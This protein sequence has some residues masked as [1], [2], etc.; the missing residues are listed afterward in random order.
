MIVHQ[1]E[2]TSVALIAAALVALGSGICLG[3]EGP[4][5]VPRFGVF[6]RSFEV[7]G[8]P[9][10]AYTD[11]TATDTFRGPDGGTNETP[12]FWDGE[13]TW[14]V[15]FS[16]NA[17]GTWKWSVRSDRA[18]LR[19]QS[20]S[21]VCTPSE[22][23]GG[24]RAMADYPHHFEY[25]DG[26][27]FFWLG[28]TQWA[29]FAAIEEEKLSRE[30]VQHYVGARAAQGFNYVQADLLRRPN[31]G[32]PPFEDLAAETLNPAYW[33]EVDRRVRYMNDRGITVMLVLA[34]GG[35]KG[36]PKFATWD[37][38]PSQE[39]RLRYARYVAA[40][41]SAYNVGFCVSGESM[42]W[43]T[44]D[45]VNDVM[46]AIGREIERADPHGRMITIHAGA[47]VQ[48]FTDETWM[49]FGDFQQNYR[50]LHGAIL[51]ARKHNAPV[52]NSEYAY[53]LR[54][55]D[56]DGKVD[57][58]HS[59]TLRQIRNA[60]WDIVM[61]GGYVVTGFGT[62]YL[63]GLR[64]PGPFDVDTPRNDD[65]E[66]DVGHVRRLFEDLEW[67]KLQP[68]D[69]LLTGPPGST[70][71][72]LRETGR[73]YVAYARGSEGRY[74]L[75]LGDDARGAYEVRQFDPR[76]G[77]F[78]DLPRHQ[79]AGPVTLDVQDGNDWVFVLKRRQ[80]GR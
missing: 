60:T 66:E 74:Q 37:E 49:S 21:F 75:A 44:T 79:G 8:V 40:R 18:G 57:K 72:C 30:T 35:Q 17:E 6:E 46:R 51:G 71:Y 15:R 33:D 65:W 23:A 63:G 76:T 22:H 14:R 55:Q 38:F 3:G 7:H 20:G 50:S 26:T 58:P 31:E 19:E 64:D 59:A 5:R 68:E 42:K 52:V 13:A 27:P 43:G 10:N 24:I 41:Y 78:T 80:S 69:A 25:Q 36:S 32:G 61:A 47:S 39:A 54:D 56:G 9:A 16:P 29:A 62:T 53:Y 70:C 2:L 45:A 12:L 67:W 48:E 77:R 4:V 28:D 73:Q 1:H 34:W 11:L